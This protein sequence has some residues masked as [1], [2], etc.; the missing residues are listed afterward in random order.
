V[1]SWLDA[2][3]HDPRGRGIAAG[4]GV[5]FE[6]MLAASDLADLDVIRRHDQEWATT[7]PSADFDR[8]DD[9]SDLVVTANSTAIAQ[10]DGAGEDADHPIRDGLRI[11]RGVYRFGLMAWILDGSLREGGAPERLP[12]ARFLAQHFHDRSILTFVAGRAIELSGDQRI[13]WWKLMMKPRGEDRVVTMSFIPALITAYLSLLMDLLPPEPTSDEL[14]LPAEPW[15][16]EHNVILRDSINRAW[17]LDSDPSFW[18]GRDDVART[19]QDPQIAQQRRRLALAIESVVEDL[20]RARAIR[21]RRAE[22][23]PVYRELFIVTASRAWATHRTIGRALH[24]LGA[25]HSAAVASTVELLR[26]T[27]PKAGFVGEGS[28]VHVESYGEQAGRQAAASETAHVLSLLG[29]SLPPT[30]EPKTVERRALAERVIRAVRGLRAADYQPSLVLTPSAHAIW[31]RLAVDTTALADERERLRKAGLP[32]YLLRF[33][34]AA[35][36]G[37]VVISLPAAELG[38][39]LV[40]DAGRALAVPAEFDPSGEDLEI[41]LA[42][43]DP[44]ELES[45]LASA[46]PTMSD[47][48]LAALLEEQLQQLVVLASADLAYEVADPRAIRMIDI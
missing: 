2:A 20:Q 29:E 3:T 16:E 18:G 12:V 30:C 27:V 34:R 8:F 32:E 15:I 47:E 28:D 39:I 23:V 7:L 38:N 44:A 17:P 26:S 13:A 45:E 5:V 22:V 1:S 21:I 42:E 14:D 31:S 40:V 25:P 37:V 10:F 43:H 41:R 46:D 9:L 24:A 6:M 48:T 35:I 11:L 36:E 19:E 33:V 4:F